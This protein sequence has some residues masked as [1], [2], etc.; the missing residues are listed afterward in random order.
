MRSS[1]GG[2]VLVA[3]TNSTCS[4]AAISGSKSHT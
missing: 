2:F 1:K 4:F 3:A